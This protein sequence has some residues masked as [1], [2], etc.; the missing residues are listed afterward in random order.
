MPSFELPNRLR[1]MLDAPGYHAIVPV[2]EPPRDTSFVDALVH[3]DAVELRIDKLLPC[4]DAEL[5]RTASRYGALP[6]L[7]T[8]RSRAEG[9]DWVG[10]VDDKL[11]LFEQLLPQVDGVDVELQS[12]ALEGVIEMVKDKPVV[13]S[14]HHFDPTN[15][16]RFRQLDM[17]LYNAQSAGADYVKIA[18]MTNTEEALAELLSFMELNATESVIAVAMGE[19][20]GEGRKRLLEL[21]SRATFAYVGSTPVVPGQLALAE[22]AR[23]RD[24]H[25]QGR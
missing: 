11:A 16:L 23:F 24:A 10:S 2:V 1:S 15:H 4:S 14:A 9:G 7:A 8:I 13:V 20:G 17:L 3:A 18:A 12:V 19:F 25:E 5:S 6:I 22:F 21:G